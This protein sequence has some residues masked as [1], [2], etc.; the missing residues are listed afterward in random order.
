[1]TLLAAFYEFII[2]NGVYVQAYRVMVPIDVER[3]PLF[4]LFPE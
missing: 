4:F 2:K 1:V 3:V